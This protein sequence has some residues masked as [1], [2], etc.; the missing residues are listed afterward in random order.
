[1]LWFS[2]ASDCAD[3]SRIYELLETTGNI[4][5]DVVIAKIN[6]LRLQADGRWK[7]SGEEAGALMESAEL[8]SDSEP[9]AASD[10]PNPT[11]SEVTEHS[12]RV[13]LDATSHGRQQVSLSWVFLSF[14]LFSFLC[15][16]NTNINRESKKVFQ[17]C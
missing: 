4:W 17:V 14:R 7:L 1:M 5:R 12:V 9:Q 8:T 10:E 6:T 16:Q 15:S 13:F 2:S 3:G 11:F